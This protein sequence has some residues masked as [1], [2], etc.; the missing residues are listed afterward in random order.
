M[1]R[2]AVGGAVALDQGY[3][4]GCGASQVWG[5]AAA[6]PT[7]GGAIGLH[8]GGYHRGGYHHGGHHDARGGAYAGRGARAGTGAGGGGGGGGGATVGSEDWWQMEKFEREVK[9][10]LYSVKEGIDLLLKGD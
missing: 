10:F 7:V 6:A 3:R 9:N 5:C 2:D 4:G 1:V 8:L